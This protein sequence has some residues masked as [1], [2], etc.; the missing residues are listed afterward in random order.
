MFSEASKNL[1]TDTNKK[2]FLVLAEVSLGQSYNTFVTP[3][4]IP[5]NHDSV[6]V[7]GNSLN[8][9]GNFLHKDGYSIPLGSVQ[10]NSQNGATY[11]VADPTQFRVKYILHVEILTVAAVAKFAIAESL[12]YSTKK[13]PMELFSW[14]WMGSV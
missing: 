11:F 8:P 13:M 2:V 3:T 1:A 14:I 4:S 6:L 12:V 10:G 5:A 9:Q 7:Y